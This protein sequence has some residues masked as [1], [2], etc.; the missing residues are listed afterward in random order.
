LTIS[1]VMLLHIKF[2][3]D[4]AQ[5]IKQELILN[6]TFTDLNE[7]KIA[8]TSKGNYTCGIFETP[9]EDYETICACLEQIKLQINSLSEIEIDGINYKIEK[10]I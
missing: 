7:G 4:W 9:E 3:C 10:Y 6:L 8:E 5:I 1:E 2:S